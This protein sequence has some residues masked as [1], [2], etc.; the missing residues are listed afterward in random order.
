VPPRCANSRGRG[1]EANDFGALVTIPV[2]VIP[3]PSPEHP[4][5]VPPTKEEP[6]MTSTVTIPAAG[7]TGAREALLCLLNE[8][9]ESI[10]DTLIRPEYELHPEWFEAD[11]RRFEEIC[12][13]LDVI[14]WDAGAP[15]RK[16]EVTSQGAHT[17]RDAIEGCLPMVEQWLS[18]ATKLRKRRQH[19]DSVQA[20]WSLLATLRQATPDNE[21]AA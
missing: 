6:K 19:R 7:I 13:L 8:P 14:G 20:R 16:V 12:R 3:A 1:T 21:K 5:T 11:R 4:A 15:A 9:A 18:E 17:V 2:Q 10:V